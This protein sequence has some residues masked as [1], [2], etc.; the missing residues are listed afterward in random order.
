MD[1]LM[2]KLINKMDTKQIH[3]VGICEFEKLLKRYCL[4]ASESFEDYVKAKPLSTKRKTKLFLYASFLFVIIIK[5]ALSRFHPNP[6]TKIILG[7]FY[8]KMYDLDIYYVQVIM[9]AISQ[10]FIVLVQQ[11]LDKQGKFY[12]LQLF[13]ELKAKKTNSLLKNE[14]K[15]LAWTFISYKCLIFQMKM[16]TI[17]FMITFGISVYSVYYDRS[18]ELT[19]PFVLA[20]VAII[21]LLNLVTMIMFSFYFVLIGISS[22]F[23]MSL[24]VLYLKYIFRELNLNLKHGIRLGYN[25]LVYKSIHD[26]MQFSKMIAQFRY[27][28]N[29]ILGTFYILVPFILVSGMNIAI[30]HDELALWLRLNELYLSAIIIALCYSMNLI[31]SW[32]PTN[33]QRIDKHLYSVFSGKTGRKLLFKLKVYSLLSDVTERFNG[34]KCFT[35]LDLDR[36]AFYRF[37][38]ILSSAYILIYNISIEK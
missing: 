25:N 16:M 34:F 9:A 28:N 12:L 22:V 6:M 3:Y 2:K 27:H 13:H 18:Q 33:N 37:F 19:S 8:Y 36:M 4:M 14:K 35:L 30:E 21:L 15:F 7:D 31:A 32:I 5:I 17:I 20:C 10:L 29:Y 26:H 24:S 11:Y 1:Y 23:L 38:W